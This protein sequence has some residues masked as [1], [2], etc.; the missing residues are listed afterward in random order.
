MT[1]HVGE[2]GFWCIREDGEVIIKHTVGGLEAS[3]IGQ[4]HGVIR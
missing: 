4:W 3:T 2:G 1:W